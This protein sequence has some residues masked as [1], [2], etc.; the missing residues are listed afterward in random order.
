MKLLILVN[1]DQHLEHVLGIA[2]AAANKKHEVMI[3]TMDEG[4]RLLASASFIELAG[5]ANLSMSICKHSAERLEIGLEDLPE[6][7]TVGSQLQNALM[8]HEADRMVV[9]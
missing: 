6:E 9:F 5:L 7:I 3:F 1:S 4:V 2:R 8:A